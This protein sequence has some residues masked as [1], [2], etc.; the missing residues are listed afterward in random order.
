VNE[1]GD[2]PT[3]DIEVWT[4]TNAN[5]TNSGVNCD[6]WDSD[7]SLTTGQSGLA[8]AKD[9]AWTNNQAEDCDVSNRLYCFGN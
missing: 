2:T 5:G 1:F 3:G 6:N 9:E 8:N 7:S 4:G